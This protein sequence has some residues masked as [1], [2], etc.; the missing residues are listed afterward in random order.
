MQRRAPIR[1]R[2]PTTVPT[3][4][5]PLRGLVLGLGIPVLATSLPLKLSSP[6]QSQSRDMGGF[7]HCLKGGDLEERRKMKRKE[8]EERASMKKCRVMGERLM[9]GRMLAIWGNTLGK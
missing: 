8:K 5:V 2:N 4:A 6:G 1:V 7:S 9:G 3:A